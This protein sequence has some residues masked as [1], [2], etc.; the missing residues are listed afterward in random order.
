MAPSLLLDPALITSRVAQAFDKTHI[1]ET[2]SDDSADNSVHGGMDNATHGVITLN[3]IGTADTIKAGGPQAMVSPPPLV[4]VA[5]RGEIARRVIRTCTKLGLDTLAVY[6]TPD[7]L[8]PHVR[9]ATFSVCLGENARAYTN[10]A[11]LLQI[12]MDEAVTA[13]HPGYGFL[14]ENE[15]FCQAVTDANIAW[16]GPRAQTM[17]DFALKHVARSLAS[18]AG[19]PVLSGSDL[20]QHVDDALAA[21]RSV[22][23]PVLLKATGGG[24]GMGI[25]TCRDDDDVR[26]Q[27]D[28]SKNQ[29]KAFFGNDG[30]FV[31]KYIEEAHHVE[32]QIFGDGL[33]DCV[34][35][36]ERECSIQR[37]HQKILEE[38]PSPLVGND[39][40]LRARLL[41]SATALGASAKYRSAGTVEFLVDGFTRQFYFLEVNA[42]LQVE[43][44]ITE[45]VNGGIDIV[46]AQLRL[47][48]PGLM[49]AG[50]EAEVMA[51]LR[52]CKRT[53][54]SIEVRINGEDPSKDFQ[55]C[56]GQV[57]YVTF[58]KC[59]NP[60]EMRVDTWLETGCTISP[61]YDSLLAKAMVWAP[62]RAEA[63]AK[64]SAMLNASQI[65]GTPNNL[66]FLRAL[67]VDSRFLAGDTS[68]RFLEKFSFIPHCVEVVAPGLQTSVQDWPGR[69]GRW[70]VGVPPSGPMDSLS[71]RLANAMV[72]NPEDAAALEFSLQG[73]TLKF[74]APALVALAGASFKLTLDGQPVQGWWQSIAIQAGQVLAIGAVEA[75]TGVRGYLAVKGGFDVP[76]Y[77]GSRST[78]PSGKFGGYQGRYLRCGDSLALGVPDAA[79]T[80]TSPLTLPTSLL[81]PGPISRGAD[82]SAQWEV[83]SL[84]GPHADPDF[85]TQQFMEGTF[86]G[87]SY[88]VHYNSNRLGVRLVGAKPE[89]VRPDGG[90][91]GTHP[92]NV[93]DHVYALGAVNFT[94]DHPVVLTV[95]G[96]SLGGFVCPTTITSTE[97]WKVGQVRP[98]DSVV[99]RRLTL[100][101]AY[102]ALLTTDAKISAL[103]EAARTNIAADKAEVAVKE[104]EAA[105]AALAAAAAGHM[106]ETKPLLAS[107][108][109]SETHPGAEYRLA[110]DRYIQVEFGPQEL[111][112]A[113]RVRVHCLQQALEQAQVPGFIEA[114]PGVRSLMVEYDMRK[115]TP[116][117]LLDTLARLDASLPDPHGLTL[118]SRVVK[119]PMCFDD[120]ATRA[121]ITK[122][123][124]SIRPEAPYLPSN[125]DYIASN[126][127]LEGGRDEV[128]SVLFSAS[129]M[130]LGLGDVYLG[131]P[132]AV[133]LD[134]RHRL[135]T[136]K[137]N[138]A[139][140]FTEEGTVGIGGS[141][142]CIYPMDS[143]GGYQLVG[144]TLPI[145][146]TYARSGPFTPDKPWLLRNFD[147]VQFFSVSEEELINLREKFSTGRYELS[148]EDS[149][150][151]MAQYK[152]FIKGL[153]PEVTEIKA[154]QR[155]AMDDQLQAEAESLA[156]LAQ[157]AGD[158]SNT[159][160]V[161]EDD[162]SQWAGSE[163]VRVNAP[164]TA[165]VWNVMAVV[166]E[167]VEANEVLLVLEAMKMESPVLAPCAG[168]VVAIK[169]QPSTLA[170][171]GSLL[172]VIKP[173]P[174]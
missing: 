157:A 41:N 16:L 106:P 14:S 92:S 9:D 46:E 132:C 77:L 43:H 3:P 93:H 75:S 174:Q 53:G 107:V 51:K 124:K 79:N 134:P 84:P 19:V 73:P 155:A 128:Q 171:V 61:H 66:E 160:P 39:E 87:S 146:N 45:M 64:M 62:T 154:R 153:E 122:Y 161:D 99:F 52:A 165:N 56:P 74:H 11:L 10:Q 164:F 139:R 36:G 78:F 125:I 81:P 116:A 20:V 133:P 112:L 129:Y 101:D 138:P 104:A 96:P 67:V 28:A 42:R 141:Y 127:G 40:E 115:V 12:A 7:A 71:H 117:S 26:R 168:T 49:P 76:L 54:H 114:S 97:M 156:R 89:W 55:P 131:A 15:E 142:M 90:E 6:T 111:D 37:R 109:A 4:M 5:N 34:A 27:F 47:Q 108:P 110:G 2:I 25:Y 94:G 126:N 82:G 35:L 38:S 91:G 31:E 151:N 21:A 68:T 147:Q 105:A 57:G 150:F 159:P 32:V 1:D 163:Y 33:G 58:P 83:G 23:Y 8:A 100:P 162:E 172:V 123:M 98:S 145:W 135:V 48:V 30:V 169:A 143:P 170:A 130:V 119:L 70:A 158:S 17:H 148:I 85:I 149:E 50:G 120:S 29:G 121:A 113:L 102:A 60:N 152:E 69:V 44:G 137:Y 65:Q 88:S 173:N 86:Y 140:T 167:P 24:G 80:A 63:A 95:D 59:D 136:T 22:G 166:G 118:P 18:A 13:I 72:G 103:R 144:R